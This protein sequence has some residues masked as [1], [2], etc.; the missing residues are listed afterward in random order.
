M[1]K[2]KT[3]FIGS[4]VVWLLLITFVIVGGAVFL[5]LF[6]TPFITMNGP[7]SV[8]VTTKEGYE[9]PGA[10]ASYFFH[11]ISEHVQIDSN[12][13]DKKVGTYTVTYSVDYLGKTAQETRKVSVVDREPPQLT[14]NEGMEITIRP[15]SSFQDPGAVAI[16]DSDGDVTDRITAKGFV[17]VYNKGTYEIEYTVADSY[18]N[19]ATATRTVTVKGKPLR[20]EQGV[21]FL[22]FDDGPSNTVTPEIL[23]ILEKNKVPATFFVIGYDHD[24]AKIELMKRAL[25]DG[26]TIGI[27]GQSHDYSKIYKSVPAFMDNVT[28]LRDDL[29]EDLDYEAFVVRFPGGSS[30]TISEQYC[31]GIMTDL[32]RQVQKEGYMYSDWNVDSTDASANRVPA[33]TLI[34]SVKKGCRKDTFNVILMHDS[35]AKKTTAKAL[36]EI[37]KWAKKEG[38]VFK[39]MTVDSPTV[40]HP[41]NN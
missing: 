10:K 37:I 30:N 25:Q 9:E 32:V 7:S 33:K 38:Y 31:K 21:I 27:H 28:T 41:V 4:K 24:P 18:G 1:K 26:C 17:D 19:E 5:Y 39:A 12:V 2:K 13:N 36:P 35:D 20:E 3:N 23:E 34:K 11:D 15:G 6:T 16:D 14:L 40:H 29:K 8:E 22:T